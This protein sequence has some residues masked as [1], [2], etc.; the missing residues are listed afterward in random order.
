MNGINLLQPNTVPHFSIGL[1]RLWSPYH[2]IQGKLLEEVDSAKSKIR[3]IIYGFHLP[4]LTD[5]LIQKHKAG[6]DVKCILDLSQSKGVAEREEVQKLRDAGVDVV[7]G[8]SPVAGQILHEKAINIDTFRHI[9]GSYNFSISAAKQ[10]NHMDF[11]WSKDLVDVFSEVFDQL[12][13]EVVK[14]GHNV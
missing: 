13:E 11:F 5:L 12:R 4:A 1:I 3:M 7:V 6:L 8:T 2:D 9:S 10:F 14:E